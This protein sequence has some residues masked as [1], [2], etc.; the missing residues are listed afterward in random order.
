MTKIGIVFGDN[1][2]HRTFRSVLKILGEALRDGIEMDKEK[3]LDMVNSFSYPCY[4]LFQNDWDTKEKLAEDRKH[5][6]EYLTIKMGRLLLDDE[7][8]KYKKEVDWNNGE[9]WIMEYNNH[10]DDVTIYSY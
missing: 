4:L 2:F 9:T 8:D 6:I 1:D 10:L 3:I 7:V 5:D